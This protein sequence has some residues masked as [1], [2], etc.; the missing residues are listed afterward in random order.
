M[1]RCSH[2]KFVW[3]FNIVEVVKPTTIFTIHATYSMKFLIEITKLIFLQNICKLLQMY[4]L[5]VGNLILTYFTILN[6]N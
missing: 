1:A 3:P 2:H 4:F 5:L 6:V